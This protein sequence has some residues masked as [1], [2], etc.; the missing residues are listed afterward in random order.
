MLSLIPATFVI[1]YGMTFINETLNKT[2]TPQVFLSPVLLLLLILVILLTGSLSG[3]LIGLNYSHIP[4]LT[5]SPGRSN[6]GQVKPVELLI[7]GTSLR[8][9][10][11]PCF[12]GTT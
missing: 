1:D 8:N 5:F 2:L 11:N 4:A 6:S 9:F 12:R 7:S 10:Y 3:W